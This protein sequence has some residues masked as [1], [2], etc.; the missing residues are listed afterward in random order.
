MDCINIKNNKI[1]K[2][3]K[4]KKSSHFAKVSQVAGGCHL[5]IFCII[6][7]IKIINLII[8]KGEGRGSSYL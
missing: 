2:K 1:Y 3:E 7:N 6:K 4:K 8:E 5:L